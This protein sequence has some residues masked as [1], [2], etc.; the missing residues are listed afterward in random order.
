VGVSRGGKGRKSEGSSCKEHGSKIERK[1]ERK[2]KTKRQKLS[3]RVEE[4]MKRRS[5]SDSEEKRKI[6]EEPL[7]WKV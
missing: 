5:P 6:E 1:I 7:G 4:S 3:V 2:S